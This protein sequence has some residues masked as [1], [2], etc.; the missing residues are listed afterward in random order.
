MLQRS[1]HPHRDHAATV[2]GDGDGRSVLGVAVTILLSHQR[3]LAGDVG[4]VELADDQVT[5]SGD[6]G[7]RC[8]QCHAGDGRWQGRLGQGLSLGQRPGPQDLVVTTGGHHSTVAAD[9]H[10]FDR[11]VRAGEFVDRLAARNHPAGHPLVVA[12]GDQVFAV[13][14]ENRGTHRT[15]VGLEC[16]QYRWGP[17]EDEPV[18]GSTDNPTGIAGQSDGSQGAGVAG[19]SLQQFAGQRV[20]QRDDVVG[21]GRGHDRPV[22]IDGQV[23]DG[24]RSDDRQVTGDSGLSGVGGDA[25]AEDPV[26][27]G[28]GDHPFAVGG[29]RQGHQWLVAAGVGPGG[30]TGGG[31]PLTQGIVGA[32]GDQPPSF[33]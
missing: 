2:R 29:N 25:P 28:R 1:V 9:G 24:C 10:C 18:V 23:G 11:P 32:A 12:G 8:V 30:G 31:V 5:G 17:T 3:R 20:P 6:G 33:R 22:A 7:S 26:V 16:G 15:L 13:G 19:Q 14:G 4:Q 27:V 21:P